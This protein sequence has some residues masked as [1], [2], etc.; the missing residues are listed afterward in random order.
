MKNQQK[1]KASL[2][3]TDVSVQ[4]CHL[5]RLKQLFMFY[6]GTYFSKG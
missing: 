5:V 2:N 1:I 6:W 3:G 4:K